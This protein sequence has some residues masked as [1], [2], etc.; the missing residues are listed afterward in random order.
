M[1]IRNPYYSL[2]ADAIIYERAKNG[3]RRNWKYYTL[4]PISIF[5]G[6]N[7]FTIAM[8]IGKIFGIWI[9]FFLD[10]KISKFTV[11]N[12]TISGIITMILPFIIFNYFMVIYRNRYLEIIN[13]HHHRHGKLYIGY[14]LTSLIIS[15][16]FIWIQVAVQ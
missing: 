16:S 1:I 11:I 7:Y 15:I 8:L 9:M 5:M 12:H 4:L 14:I 3:K 13:R 10:V 2:W 6:I